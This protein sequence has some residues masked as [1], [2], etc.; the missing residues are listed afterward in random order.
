MPR[1]DLS[2]LCADEAARQELFPVTAEKLYLAHAGVAPLTG[3]AQQALRTYAERGA[4]HSQERGWIWQQVADL[5]QAC[6]QLLSCGSDEIALIGPTALGLN[7]VAL[8][9]DWQAGDEVVYYADDYPANVYPWAG[10]AARGVR[11]VALR[12]GLQGVITWPVVE[13]ALSERTRLVA[14]ASCNFLSGYR[15]DIDGIGARLQERGIRFCVDGIQTLGAFPTPT[16]H[17]DFL[18]ADSHKWLCGPC[19]AG[20]FYCDRRRFEDLRPALTG[21]WNVESPNYIAQDEVRFVDGAQR[22]EPGTLNLPGI[23]AMAASLNLLLDL[24]IDAIGAKILEL[25]QQLLDGVRSKGWQPMLATLEDE[26]EAETWRSGILSLGHPERDLEETYQLLLRQGAI[27]SLRHDR[28]GRAWLRL[29]PH[30]YTCPQ[31]IA[32]MVE[33]L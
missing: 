30:A 3:P 32:Q 15:I 7:L 11:P 29:S 26:P 14:L 9:L 23:V 18:A 25:R 13:A 16:T 8:G 12:T 21:A 19:G 28:Q 2:R 10:L 1:M 22:F 33:L 17:V 27:T 31:G 24:G 4:V 6:G 5:R 20:L